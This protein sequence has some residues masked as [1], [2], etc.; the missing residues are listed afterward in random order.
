MS[1][2]DPSGRAR[3]SDVGG[4]EAELPWIA[5]LL[6][7]A[8]ASLFA[9]AAAVKV[10]DGIDGV[11]RYYGSIFRDSLLPSFLVRAHATA[12]LPLELGLALWFVLGW[13]PRALWLTGGLTLITLAVG[14]VFAG[15]YEIAADNY[16]YVA[17]SGAGLLTAPHDRYR[18]GGRRAGPRAE[19]RPETNAQSG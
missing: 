9:S 2:T 16:V 11:V 19:V 6:R 13:K 3:S 14:M 17:L 12:I 4:S 10:P 5:L 8:F 7:L 15:N 18:V 1:S